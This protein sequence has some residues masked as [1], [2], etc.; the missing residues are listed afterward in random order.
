MPGRND[1]NG[2]HVQQGQNHRPPNGSVNGEQQQNQVG[3]NQS[4]APMDFTC[5]Q[6]GRISMHIFPSNSIHQN[7]GNNGWLLNGQAV[8]SGHSFQANNPDQL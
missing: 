7:N 2:Q 4:V 6:D 5:Q 1:C 8:S 3:S